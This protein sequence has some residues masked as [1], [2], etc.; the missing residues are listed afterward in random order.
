MGKWS[1]VLVAVLSVFVL[2]RE[3]IADDG[4]AQNTTPALTATVFASWRSE[5]VLVNGYAPHGGDIFVQDLTVSHRSGFYIDLWNSVSPTGGWSSDGGDEVDY[6]VGYAGTFGKFSVDASYFYF[7][8]RNPG[9][10]GANIGDASLRL[11]FGAGPIRP[12]IHFD[13][14]FGT[15]PEILEGG[16][17]YRIGAQATAKGALFGRDLSVDALLAGHDGQ[18]GNPVQRL[19]YSRVIVAT[20]VRAPGGFTLLPRVFAQKSFR[21]NGIARD[22]VWAELGLTRSF[23]W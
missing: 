12:Y 2:S 8:L 9:L 3:A 21:A 17:G 1:V 11:A 15:K 10:K 4:A 19:S 16:L 7:N 23:S 22:R 20:S 5:Y 18:A 13:W 14:L 6:G